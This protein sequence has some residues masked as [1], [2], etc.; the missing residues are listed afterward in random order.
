MTSF[1]VSRPVGSCA[2]LTILALGSFLG[3]CDDRIECVQNCG[4]GGATSTSSSTTDAS[5]SSTVASSTS[6]GTQ[7]P[8]A[9]PACASVKGPVP[10]TFSADEGATLA[11]FE[12]KFTGIAYFL[13][14]VASDAPNTLFADF[15]GGFYESTDAGCSFTLVHATEVGPATLV[16]SPGGGAFGFTQNDVGL[17]RYEPIQGFRHLPD[18]PETIAG[19]AVDPNDA[20]HVRLVS[21]R[22][23]TYESKN[24]GETFTELTP[25]VFVDEGSVY[26]AVFDPNDLDHVWLGV[27]TTGGFVTTN[28]GA[29]WTPVTG[30]GTPEGDEKANGFSAVISPL[31]GNV[32]WV[33]GFSLGKPATMPPVPDVRHVFRSADGGLTFTPVVTESPDVTLTN[34]V[35]MLADPADVNGLYFE[36]GTYYAGYGTDIFH[37]DHATGMVTKTHNP[38]D[39]MNVFVASPADPTFLYF[40][41]TSSKIPD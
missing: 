14:L 10:L 23:R 5:S 40:G 25:A 1:L 2:G 7:L 12:A 16:P 39:D 26:T 24:A 22:G 19:V 6:T 3:G 32:V 30:L 38:Y 15:G 28:A 18:L 27:I 11:P 20:L 37:Y 36:F 29:T 13:G 9:K 8:W 4:T 35:P 21:S 41:V 17:Y 33:E 34:G 31:D